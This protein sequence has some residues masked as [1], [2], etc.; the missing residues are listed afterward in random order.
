[1]GLNNR[2]RRERISKELRQ[3]KKPIK[4][5]DLAKTF[6]VSRQVIVQDIALLRAK[7]EEII[8]TPQGYIMFKNDQVRST[9]TIV[10]KHQGYQEMEDELQTMIDYG[11]RIM[12]VIVEHPIYGEIRGI[13]DISYKGEL[14]DFMIKVKEDKA[15]PLSSLTGGVHIHT[16]QIP[17]E[18]AFQRMERALQE[19]GYLI[20][21]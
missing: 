14:E 9:K 8:A 3:A 10:T 21:E 13:L 1:M 2:E 11:V 5:V 15:E 12:D 16:V 20:K 6:N 4:G 7:G 18:E 19:K 17:S